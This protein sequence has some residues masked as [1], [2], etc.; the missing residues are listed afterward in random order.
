MCGV[1]NKTN[2]NPNK[3]LIKK[4]ANEFGLKPSGYIYSDIYNRSNG[5]QYGYHPK[6]KPMFDGEELEFIRK[7]VKA[8]DVSDSKGYYYFID[9]AFRKDSNIRIFAKGL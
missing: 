8:C 2:D 6:E 9:V 1:L 5:S 3:K 4:I 7:F